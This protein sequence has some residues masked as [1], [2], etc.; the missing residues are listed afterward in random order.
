MNLVENAEISRGSL[1]E[2]RDKDGRTPLMLAA[3]NGHESV[4][5][6]LWAQRQPNQYQGCSDIVGGIWL[7]HTRD[8]RYSETALFLALRK[9]RREI[10]KFLAEKGGSGLID[11]MDEDGN[12]ALFTAAR[13]GDQKLVKVLV[14]HGAKVT[15]VS[16]SKEA[17]KRGRTPLL[18]AAAAGHLHVVQ[19]LWGLADD[20]EFKGRAL[21]LA[22]KEDRRDI[23]KFLAEKGGPDLID[24]RE[25]DRELSFSDRDAGIFAL[26][27][28]ARDGDL[29]IVK[30]LVE[31]GGKV[32]ASVDPMHNFKYDTPFGIAAANG[33]LRVLEVLWERAGSDVLKVDHDC[34]YG[35]PF[36]VLLRALENGHRDVVKFLAEKGG[37]D[38][39]NHRPGGDDV[40]IVLAARKG[41]LDIVKSLVGHGGVNQ[42]VNRELRPWHGSSALM[43]AAKSGHLDVVKWMWEHADDSSALEMALSVEYLHYTDSRHMVYD[44]EHAVCACDAC[45]PWR[46]ESGSIFLRIALPL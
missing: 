46:V 43:E 36:G 40:A 2:A 42:C 29:E 3:M 9:N 26:F 31:H 19:Y 14:E 18:I 28:A 30:C 41:D 23:V 4:V 17:K 6:W 37:P 25:F 21:L 27:I 20:D 12:T 44:Y 11:C 1:V 34:L 39:I 22:L 5:K 38:L 33:H 35:D 24:Y 13:N 32:T 10:V 45:C 7:P 8:C 15:V 16:Y